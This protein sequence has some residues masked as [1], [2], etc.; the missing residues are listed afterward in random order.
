M[1]MKNQAKRL[2]GRIVFKRRLPAKLGRAA[3]F[4]SCSAGWG[5]AYK[6]AD[7]FDP[8]LLRIAT[9]ILKPAD[10][11]W[12]IGANIGLFT[13]AA[14]V[15]S[16]KDGKVIAF[17]P[18]TWLVHL[19]RRTSA[20]QP[21]SHA[22]IVVIPAAIGSTE[23]LRSFSVI[24]SSR[25][26][27]ALTEYG[28]SQTD[29]RD[30]TQTVPCFSLDWLLGHLPPPRVIKVDVEGAE[31]EVLRGGIRMLRDIRPMLILE[32]N[33]ECRAEL[34]RL[35]QASAYVLY[36]GLKP[37]SEWAPIRIASWS[38]VAIPV[39]VARDEQLPLSQTN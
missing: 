25:A 10:V 36:T 14:A 5:F 27:N 34:T 32:V 11:I 24:S 19:L 28:L 12:D 1:A 22:P 4:A 20:I 9:E 23:A 33:P 37:R 35:L 26:F 2:L 17:E 18:D 31:L 7:R 16:G 6:S 38:T 29:S 3:F 8:D 30:E 15:L 21:V 39:E 13:L